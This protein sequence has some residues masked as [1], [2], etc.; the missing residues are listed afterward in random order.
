[1][2]LYSTL[3]A[4]NGKS[5]PYIGKLFPFNANMPA[6]AVYVLYIHRLT[7]SKYSTIATDM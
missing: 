3:L 4:L 6:F 1:M 5:L 2:K 7:C